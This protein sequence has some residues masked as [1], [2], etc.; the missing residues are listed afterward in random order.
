[1]PLSHHPLVK[2]FPEYKDQIH[3]LKMTNH[4]FS[5]LVEQYE[6]IDK[7][8]FRM[9]SNEEPDSDQHIQ[10]LKKKRLK[11]KDELYNIIKEGKCT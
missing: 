1:M 4:H 6:D 11:L 3:E 10:E 2:E 8:I 9:E 5:K 7:H